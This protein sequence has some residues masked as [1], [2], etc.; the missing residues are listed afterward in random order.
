M[1]ALSNSKALPHFVAKRTKEPKGDLEEQR[2]QALNTILSEK[3]SSINR[4]HHD[5][6]PTILHERSAQVQQYQP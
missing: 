4:R 2:Q 5:H 6:P 3:G 1:L